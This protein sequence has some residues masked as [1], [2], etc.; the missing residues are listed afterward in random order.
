MNK[1]CLI[2]PYFGK[3]NNYFEL[4]LN[5]YRCNPTV[6]WLILSEDETQYSYPD[7]IKNISNFIITPPNKFLHCKN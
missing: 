2:T 3:F 4:F 6:N 5:S 7:D 1:I